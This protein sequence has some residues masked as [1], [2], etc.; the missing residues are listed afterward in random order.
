MNL[1]LVP[2]QTWRL[3]LEIHASTQCAGARMMG[4]PNME[5]MSTIHTMCWAHNYSSHWNVS[6]AKAG[7]VLVDYK[8]LGLSRNTER[9]VHPSAYEVCHSSACGPAWSSMM[10]SRC[11][12][13][14]DA[15]EV[16]CIYRAVQVRQW[17]RPLWHSMRS[18]CNTPSLSCKTVEN[19]FPSRN[20]LANRSLVSYA[21]VLRAMNS[22]C[23]PQLR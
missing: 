16:T 19:S 11:L 2:P 10:R 18:A 6:E 15:G 7:L 17:L 1:N 3:A 22:N 4:S 13:G 20:A 23:C 14:S 8:L 9:P 21:I 5:H 12:L